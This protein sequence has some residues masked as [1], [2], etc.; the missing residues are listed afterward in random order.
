MP[1]SQSAVSQSVPPIH[2]ARKQVRQMSENATCQALASA[3]SLNITRSFNDVSQ[4][5]IDVPL[6]ESHWACVKND[7]TGREMHARVLTGA[8]SAGTCAGLEERG[9][10]EITD[11]LTPHVIALR[12]RNRHLH[13]SRCWVRHRYM[14]LAIGIRNR[15]GL[16]LAAV[17]GIR[18]PNQY[19]LSADAFSCP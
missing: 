4:Q 18:K 17:W 7:L 16:W 9:R 15:V 3:N 13:E 1:R 11:A 19:S 5:W 12:E 2:F 14:G 6:F 8:E 10:R